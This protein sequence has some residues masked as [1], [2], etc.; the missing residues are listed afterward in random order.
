[1]PGQVMTVIITT[2]SHQQKNPGGIEQDLGKLKRGVSS[3]ADKIA[4][5]SRKLP[6]P[7]KFK[8]AGGH[9]WLLL[10]GR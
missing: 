5:I 3:A 7:K 2:P 6:R 8:R 1:M 10:R 4:I 9:D